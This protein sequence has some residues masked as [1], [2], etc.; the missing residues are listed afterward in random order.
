VAFSELGFALTGTERL[1]KADFGAEIPGKVQRVACR[2]VDE[3][4][5]ALH[6]IGRHELNAS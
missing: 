2:V 5:L 3:L 4:G 6:R 1:T